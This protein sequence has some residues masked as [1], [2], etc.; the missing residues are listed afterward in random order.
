MSNPS[1]FVTLILGIGMNVCS[2]QQGAII[3]AQMSYGARELF[4]IGMPSYRLGRPA[5]PRHT[6][7]E[8]QVQI[9]ID[10]IEVA[11]LYRYV[12]RWFD[13]CV[14]IA[15]LI[16]LLPIIALIVSAIVAT[17]GRP[18]LFRQ[19]RAGRHGEPFTVLKFRTMTSERDSNGV[20]LPDARRLTPVGRF[21]RRT[22]LDE[23]PQFW[24]VVAGKMS[25]VGPRPL[26]VDYLP[27]YTERE[28]K[29]HEV[30]PGITGLAQV[31]GRNM[32]SW[33]E[34]LELDVRYVERLSWRLDMWILLQTIVKVFRRSDV[35]ETPS[36]L[37]G[38]LVACRTNG[39][40]DVHSRG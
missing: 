37:Q 29:R 26:F 27:Y 10:A 12:K 7:E 2:F 8:G 38:T 19:V 13:V 34:R 18:V 11:H 22:S 6:V 25:V 32:L 21:L 30:R 15:A 31:S 3:P 17:M 14:S 1:V 4:T 20:L 5:L 40:K 9:G 24:N 33:D 16:A 23:L 28:R 36:S 39:E 35:I